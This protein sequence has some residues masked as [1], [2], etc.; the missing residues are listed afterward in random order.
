MDGSTNRLEDPTG[1]TAGE[2]PIPTSPRA[3]R[4]VHLTEHERRLRQHARV[5]HLLVHVV[6]FA[7]PLAD[8]G[9]DRAAFVVVRDVADELLHDHGLARAC[10][11]EQA[12][13]RPLGERADEV[14]DLDAGLEDLDLR[15][16]LAYWRR[17]PVDGPARDAFRRGLG[18][19]GLADHV[20]HPA[21]RLDADRHRD[22]RPGR[23]H[24]VATPEPVCRIHG[25]AAHDVVADGALDLEHDR[26]TVAD[27]HPQGLEQLRLVAGRK[28]DIHH[29]ADDLADLA[30]TS[31]ALR[32]RHRFPLLT[33]QRRAW[34]RR[35]SRFP[36]APW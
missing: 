16:L 8:A 1:A 4:L 2:M 14:D 30:L 23:D 9:E 3:R 28:L 25:D 13:L 7:G 20:E 26:S 18:V 6:A 17:R 11:A 36:S 32:S 19:D 31:L 21:Q 5:L 34:P 33:S 22:G 12:D 35:R 10:S 29:G 24:L 15:L 27:L